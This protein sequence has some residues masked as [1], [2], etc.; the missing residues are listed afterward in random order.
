[1][2]N[3]KITDLTA[4]TDPLNTDVLPIVDVTSDTTKKVSIADLLKNASAG[5]AAAPG[6]AFDGDNTGIYSPGADQLAISTNGTGR[7]FVDASG[8]V[9]I[10]TTLPSEKLELGSGN[11]KLASVGRIFSVDGSRGSV[12]ISAPHDASLRRVTYGNNYYLDSDST[13]KQGSAAIGGCAL[14]LTAP[15]A[16]YGTLKFIQKQD[17]DSGGATR[18]ALVINEDGKVGIGTASPSS[19]LHLEGSNSVITMRDSDTLGDSI[20]SYILFEDSSGNDKAYIGRAGTSDLRIFGNGD[21]V[22]ATGGTTTSDEAVRIDTSGR[23]LV[24]TIAVGSTSADDFTIGGSG[25]TG[26][27]IRS[28]TSS[29]GGIHFSDGTSGDSQ[30]KGIIAY[31]HGGDYMRFYTN[32]QERLRITSDGKLG[33]GTISPDQLLELAAPRN[34]A[35]LRITST[36][37]D[38]GWSAGDKYGSI[39]FYSSDPSLAGATAPGIAA[40]INAINPSGTVGSLS[41]LTFHTSPP[42]GGVPNIERVR[43]DSSGRLGLG[44]SSPGARLEIVGETVTNGI[45]AHIK[46]GNGSSTVGLIVDGD[47]EAGD[48]LIKA[49]SNSS[50]TP[51][52]TDTKFIV[53]GQGNVGIGTASPNADLDIERATGTVEFQLQSRDSSDTFISFGDNDDGDIGQIRYAHSDNSLRFRINASEKAR[54]T[55]TG[56]LMHLGAGN[57]TTPAVQFNG[58]AP[59]NSLVIDSSG[60]LLVGTSSSRVVGGATERGVQIESTTSGPLGLSIVRNSNDSSGNTLVFGKS[61]GTALGSNTVVSN[62]DT[63]GNISFTGADGSDLGSFAA[64]IQCYVDGTPGADDMPGRLVFSTTAATESTP[65]ERMRIKNDGTINFSNVAV[66]ADNAAAKTGGLVDGD[67]YRTSTG[68]LKIVYT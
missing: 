67:V 13:Y 49:R 38:S 61:R 52:D 26:I 32:A 24:G 11:I 58:S 12:Q 68:D 9:G 48:I 1:M 53:T 16:N 66:Y 14:E 17:P 44:T 39:E 63:L 45:A 56:T 41:A 64:W 7:L 62:N 10:G 18:D 46:A 27:T 20:S 51:T 54:I 65:T 50:A 28:G 36:S 25:A 57:S 59:V 34:N 40:S 29:A 30:F 2:A 31:D 60:R 33:V 6:I 19:I 3:I 5:T 35:I 43:I 8:N 23:L 55:S 4:Y 21:T 47:D 15:N 42:V 22:F 37:N